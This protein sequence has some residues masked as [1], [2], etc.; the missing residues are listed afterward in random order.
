MSA[1]LKAGAAVGA[2]LRRF[3]RSERGTQLVELAIVMPLLLALFAATAEFGRYF[4]SYSTLAK[5]TRAGARYLATT[6]VKPGGANAAEDAR[7]KRLVVY[8]DANASDGSKPLLPGLS[9]GHVE[10]TR[11]GPVPSVP[12]TVTVRIVNYNYAPLVNLGNFAR[13]VKWAAVP[14]KPSTT[15]RYLLT[16]PSS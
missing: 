3:A 5:A 2:G 1:T 12:D 16:Q 4:Y 6:P 9:V 10:I 11:T 14:L 8:G 7:V 13:T 15:M